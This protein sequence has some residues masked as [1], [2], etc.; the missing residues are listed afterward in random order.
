VRTPKLPLQRNGAGDAI[1]AL[2]VAHYLRTGSAGQALS[3]AA[4]AVYGILAKTLEA[5]SR[6]ILLIAAQDELVTPTQVFEAE[7]LGG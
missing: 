1:A 3:N 7:V 4:S 6:E 5:G 2:F